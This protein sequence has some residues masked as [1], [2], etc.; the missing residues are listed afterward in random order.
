M[1][2]GI[3]KEVGST[4]EGKHLPDAF[5]MLEGERGKKVAFLRGNVF[6]LR[7]VS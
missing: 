3:N 6:V 7:M 4:G 2:F 5:G 1:G